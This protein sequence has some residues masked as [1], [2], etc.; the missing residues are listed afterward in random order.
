M[1]ACAGCC[2]DCQTNGLIDDL[3]RNCEQRAVLL[4]LWLCLRLSVWS[5][6]CLGRDGCFV[7][8][9]VDA[10]LCTN[11]LAYIPESVAHVCRD[12]LQKLFN[13]LAAFSHSLSM[14]VGKKASAPI[15]F[16]SMLKGAA[17]FEPKVENL[18]PHPGFFEAPAAAAA[19]AEVGSGGGG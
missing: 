9:G 6:L 16:A 18:C 7:G 14:V 19:S 4:G 17:A 15:L 11:L 8:L 12:L 2:K 3:G 1:K 13:I 10:V 5:G